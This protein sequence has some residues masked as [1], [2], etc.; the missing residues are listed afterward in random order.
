MNIRHATDPSVNICTCILASFQTQILQKD[1]V[2][3]RPDIDAVNQA[4]TQLIKTS[5]PQEAKLINDKLAEVNDRYKKVGDT[6]SRQGDVLQGLVDRVGD[7]ENRVDKV[8]DWELPVIQTLNAKE[9]GQMDTPKL[10]NKL[11]VSWVT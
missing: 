6:T 10:I 8:E 5:E 2:S 7:F 9:M 3:H 4:A 1:I 11:K